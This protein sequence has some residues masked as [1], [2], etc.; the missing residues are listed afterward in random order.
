MSTVRQ[1]PGVLNIAQ[2][3]AALAKALW[4]VEGAS[5]QGPAGRVQ[6]QAFH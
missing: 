1:V 2:R 5:S 4:L 6:V 3:E